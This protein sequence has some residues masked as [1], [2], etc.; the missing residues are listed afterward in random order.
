MDKWIPE[1]GAMVGF[2]N[3]HG[4]Q[5]GPVCAIRRDIS[6]GQLFAM[7]AISVEDAMIDQL[8]AVN[9]LDY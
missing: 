6:N 2:E 7:I 8:I 1:I 3:D 4:L 9:K 5:F